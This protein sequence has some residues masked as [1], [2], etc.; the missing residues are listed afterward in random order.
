MLDCVLTMLPSA[1]TSFTGVS[2]ILIIG[3][4][5]VSEVH[6]NSSQHIFTSFLEMNFL[7]LLSVVKPSIL[8]GA[9]SLAN[10]LN[11]QPE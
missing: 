9:V 6:D 1:I 3:P 2:L 8:K 10:M 4:I 11:Y 5:D 7:S